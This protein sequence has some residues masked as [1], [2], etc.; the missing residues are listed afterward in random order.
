MGVRVPGKGFSESRRG[1]GADRQKM[2]K[3]RA[4][5]EKRIM[6]EKKS[7][8]WKCLMHVLVTVITAR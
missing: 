5:Q 8:I 4:S 1:A 7:G 2:E 3:R 6:V